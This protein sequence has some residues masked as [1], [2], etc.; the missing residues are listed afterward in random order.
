[1]RTIIREGQIGLTP[2][3]L[4]QADLGIIDGIVHY[5]GRGVDRHDYD[6]EVDAGGC[7]VLPG[8]IDPHVHLDGDFGDT[9]TTDDMGSGTRAAVFGGTTTVMNF[10]QPRQGE[11]L[12]VLVE[13]WKEKSVS[14]W[15]HYGFHIIIPEINEERDG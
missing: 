13:R 9:V 8:G 4:I 12:S 11:T 3:A 7:W 2:H 14:S 5:L 6:L 1:M 10:I 15:A